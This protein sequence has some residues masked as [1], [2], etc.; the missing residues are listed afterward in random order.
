MSEEIDYFRGKR[1]NKGR[2]FKRYWYTMEDISRCK[3]RVLGSIRNDKSV[4]KFD[5]EDLCSVVR[6]CST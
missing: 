2:G 3:G 5:P 1:W 4:G 6:Y